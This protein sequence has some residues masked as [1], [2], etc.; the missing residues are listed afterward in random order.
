MKIGFLTKRNKKVVLQDYGVE[1]NCVVP[2][3]Q[4]TL[5]MVAGNDHQDR[6]ANVIDVGMIIAPNLSP[7][8]VF[9]PEQFAPH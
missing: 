3:C 9:S 5:G 4:I 1:G 6:K 7:Y 2:S 8:S